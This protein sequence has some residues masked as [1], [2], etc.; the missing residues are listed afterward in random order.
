M[1]RDTAKAIA[2]ELKQRIRAGRIA[3]GERVPSAREIVRVHGVAIA[4]ASRVLALLRKE[5]LVRAERGV[6]TIVRAGGRRE[7]LGREHAVRAAI[8]IADEEGVA[9][10]TLR[11]VAV[12]LGV[13]TVTVSDL[14]GDRDALLLEMIDAVLGDVPLPRASEPR[15]LVTELLRAQWKG[16]VLHPWVPALLSMT[17]PQL[18]PNGMRHTEVLL[19]AIES[20]GLPPDRTLRTAVMLLAYVRGMAIGLED[21]ARAQQDTGLSSEEWMTTRESLF[22]A[23]APRFPSLQRYAD[24]PGIDMGLEALFEEGLARLV[25]G[26]F[27]GDVGSRVV[28]RAERA[29]R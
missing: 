14:V 2:G 18:M 13:P 8:A 16:Y 22:A 12:E 1:K 26:I 23:L 15:T 21:E 10:V 24:Q 28:P 6:G 11:Q 5:G 7:Q 19:R 4:T 27:S 20:L 25:H 17:R 9:S 3:P 29:R